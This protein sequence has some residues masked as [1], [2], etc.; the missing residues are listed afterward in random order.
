MYVDD[1]V[2]ESLVTTYHPIPVLPCD[3]AEYFE[4][5]RVLDPAETPYT[6]APS[7]GHATGKALHAIAHHE[8]Q[9]NHLIHV[10]RLPRWDY[11]IFPLGKAALLIYL[12]VK[13]LLS[14]GQGILAEEK[15]DDDVMTLE[16]ETSA[17]WLRQ[18]D[19][20][21]DLD[22]PLF[23]ML[24]DSIHT[25]TPEHILY[26]W[27]ALRRHLGM[28][29]L[30][31]E[32][33]VRNS[34]KCVRLGWDQLVNELYR[35][36]LDHNK[37]LVASL[38]SLL[39]DNKTL[40]RS[41]S[42]YCAAFRIRLY[43]W[44]MTRPHAMCRSQAIDPQLKAQRF[45]FY[46]RQLAT[47][48]VQEFFRVQGMEASQWNDVEKELVD[49]PVTVEAISCNLEGA[50]PQF[51]TICQENHFTFECR[52]LNCDCRFGQD[53]LKKLLNRDSPS[54]FSCPNCRAQLH[55]PLR[56]RPIDFAHTRNLTIGLLLALRANIAS[57]CREI[58]EVPEPV[59]E[60]RRWSGFILRLAYGRQ[61]FLCGIE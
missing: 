9:E 50:T 60:I 11:T 19:H 57:L 55:E 56:W 18:I 16:S 31:L 42:M 51:C 38:P 35:L 34:E 44:R 23:H 2:L 45:R 52:K 10:S 3:H 48:I 4:Q 21:K 30:T 37:A 17:E 28:A 41:L 59:S 8:M 12:D 32:H 6:Q 47:L 39:L 25:H 33:L 20:L 58:T 24:R 22:T 61:K 53:C 7:S 26:R 27:D 1:T 54:S 43:L 49:E 15:L 40:E 13:G 29:G 14:L 5:V 36:L 46:S